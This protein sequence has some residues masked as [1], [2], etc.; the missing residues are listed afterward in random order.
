ML[1]LSAPEYPSFDGAS[2]QKAD[3]SQVVEKYYRNIGFYFLILVIFAAL[4]FYFPYFSLF[5]TFPSVTKVVHF[6]TIVLL[7]WVFTLILQPLLIRFSK[8][9]AHRIVGKSTYFIVPLVIIT[10]LGVMRQ[11]YLEVT[12]QN[13]TPAYGLKSLYTSFTGLLSIAIFYSLAISYIRKR[14]VAFHMRYMICLFLE[15]IPPTFGR[16]LG[17]WLDMRQVATHTIAVATGAAIIAILIVLDKR[18]HANYTPYVV[19]LFLYVIFTA[20]WIAI[21]SPL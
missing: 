2:L 15:F 13:H 20:S 8:F 14:N 4:G 10:C 7:L 21:G 17:Y 19:A 12:R 9:R 1:L 5:P 3:I 18:K 11:Q 6:H 16:T